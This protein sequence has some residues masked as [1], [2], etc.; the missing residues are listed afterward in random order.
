MQTM[1]FLILLSAVALVLTA[2]VALPAY[3]RWQSSANQGTAKLEAQKIMSA[4]EAVRTLGDVGSVQQIKIMLP[5]NY[6]IG[7]SNDSIILKNMNSTT[8]KYPTGAIRYRGSYNLSGP[9]EYILTVVHWTRGD[10]TNKGKEYLLEA[11]D[12]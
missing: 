7:F 5:D 10:E 1:P 2:A 3:E 12:P 6:L 8:G 4:A 11:L 9:G